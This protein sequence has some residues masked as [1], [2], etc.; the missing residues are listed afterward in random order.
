MKKYVGYLVTLI[1][2]ILP[3]N[4]FA[5]NPIADPL[6]WFNISVID[7]F[8]NDLANILSP[9]TEEYI[10]TKG[11]ELYDTDGTQIMVVT[12]PNL[13]NFSIEEYANTLFNSIGI[14][15]SEK[16]N[17]LLLLLALEEREFRVEVGDGLSG[18]LPDGKTGRFQ[19]EYIIPYLKNDEWDKGIKN[20]YD[21]FYSEIVKLN[22]LDLEYEEPEM[23]MINISPELYKLASLLFTVLQIIGI[24]FGICIKRLKK[25]S[26]E[27]YTK[28]YLLI[29]SVVFMGSLFINMLRILL[30]VPLIINLVVF[31][32]C[33][34]GATSSGRSGSSSRR[35]SSSSSRSYS[36]GSSRSSSRSSG[37]GGR[38]SGGGS[39]RR[40]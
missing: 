6:A 2:L 1:L 16:N 21:A 37:G 35:F 33:R 15:S 29:W 23:E 24:L 38:S 26:R 32:C 36:S 14:G 8:V 9:E 7:P 13:G 34:Y 25:K 12:V 30:I 5:L 20:G 4:V 10:K 27:N 11:Y 18:I 39:S 22:N 19:D 3:F 31:L 40:F 28:I 17:G